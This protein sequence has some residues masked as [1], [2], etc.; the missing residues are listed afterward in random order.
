MLYVVLE[1]GRRGRERRVRDG[2][3]C[4][5]RNR[6]DGGIVGTTGGDFGLRGG[7]G[8]RRRRRERL[9]RRGTGLLR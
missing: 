2:L 4:G 3:R 8:R 9:R 5:K 1:T 6:R 7:R